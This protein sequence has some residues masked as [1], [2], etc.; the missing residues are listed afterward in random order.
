MLKRER[1]F[2]NFIEQEELMEDKIQNGIE[3]HRKGHFKINLIGGNGEP[4]RGGSIKIRQKSHNF[5]FGCNIFKLKCFD[6]DEEN[7]LYEEKFKKLFNLA[8][9]PFYWDA[10]EPQDGNMRFEKDSSFI[11][12]RMPPELVLEFCREHDIEV[13]GHP[14]FWQ[15]M[16]PDW[17]PKDYEEIKPYL[18]RRIEEIAKRYD[19]VIKSFDCVNEVTSVPMVDHEPFIGDTHYRNFNPIN[20][21]YAEWTFK[22]TA[23]HFRKSRLILNETAAPWDDSFK[24]EVSHFYLL[25]ENLI[26]KGCRIDGIGLQYH[27]F[28][29]P[30][31]IYNLT[32]CYYNP[33]HLYNVMDCYG[34]LGRPLSITEITIPGHEDEIQAET[35]KNLYRI[36]FSHRDMEAIIYWNLGDNCAI[37]GAEG[38]HEDKFKSGL[39][40]NDFSE[41]PSFEILDDLINKQWQTNLDLETRGDHLYFK[42]FYGK[43]EV[44]VT[45][46]AKTVSRNLHLSKNGYDEFYFEIED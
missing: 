2:K 40:R 45:H 41:K 9:A 37:S 44:S 1:L 18:V 32:D 24:K 42:A 35:I 16:S 39:I 30:E 19:G 7:A 29:T 13:K 34:H 22:E 21:T 23:H 25:A 14:I 3:A 28:N 43:Y 4:L 46:G 12:R 17:L 36:W 6:T 11:D 8:T 10:F 38:W 5:K 15:V 31:N 20:G 33:K 27:N 26:N